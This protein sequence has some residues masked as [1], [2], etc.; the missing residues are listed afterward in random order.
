MTGE[1]P[2]GVDDDLPDATLFAVEI[3]PR[4]ART[5]VTFLSMGTISSEE[6]NTMD[7]IE[8]SAPYQLIS[9]RLYRM[10][11][12]GVM[13]IY[14]DLDK[15]EDILQLVHVSFAGY[16]YS[17][18]ETARR[19]R[20]ERYWWHNLYRDANDFVM[21]CPVCNWKYPP[22]FSPLFT[23]QMT[24]KWSHYIE[25]Y[26]RHGH[27]DENL[28]NHRQRAI[29]VESSSYV[30]IAEINF[31]KEEETTILDCVSVKRITFQYSRTPT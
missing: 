21:R 10:G 18:L 25:E 11:V 19:A 5:I 27:Q 9:G 26:M 15:Y 6:S 31:L 13:R 24:P 30:L 2:T 22:Q 29:E 3:A 16:H 8:D 23:I 4:W 14:P 1:S 17:R 7:I 20:F 12:D 28:P